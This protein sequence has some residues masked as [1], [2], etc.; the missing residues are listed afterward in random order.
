MHAN[1]AIQK[2][3]ASAVSTYRRYQEARDA[4]W[5]ALLRFRVNTLPVDMQAVLEELGVT[6]LPFPNPGE[7][8]RLSAL[9]AKTGAKKCLSLRIGGEWRVFFQP[10]ACTENELRFSLAHELGHLILQHPTQPLAPGARCFP[11]EPCPG[12]AQE[13]PHDLSDYAADIFAL[14]LLAP[15]CVLHALRADTPGKIA[16]L[17]GLP[18]RAAGLRD[19][20]MAL[21]NER[22]AFFS[23]PLER[24]VIAQFQ[25]FIGR[26]ASGL[27]P[28]PVSPP[29]PPVPER[30][31][32][33]LPDRA[34]SPA[35]PA[36]PKKRRCVWLVP[37]ML[38]LAALLCAYWFSPL[39]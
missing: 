38:A 6:L 2:K 20:R 18:P 13:E 15:A 14:R 39:R 5:R 21:L 29:A 31:A 12:D 8:P 7:E 34:V 4:A 11:G 26:E 32:L 25:P 36:P 22:D 10:G 35:S 16:A 27:A 28:V 24:Q 1:R 9:I 3:G 23:H 30:P 17:C 33:P 19:Q 37:V